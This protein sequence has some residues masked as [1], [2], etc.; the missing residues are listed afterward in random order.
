MTISIEQARKIL[1]DEYKNIPNESIW[2]M[3]NQ[4]HALCNLV[5]DRVERHPNEDPKLNKDERAVTKKNK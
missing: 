4:M 1:W 5:R 2:V 3:I